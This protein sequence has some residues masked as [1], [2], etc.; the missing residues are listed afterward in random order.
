MSAATPTTRRSAAAA[1]AT[2]LAPAKPGASRDA[3]TGAAGRITPPRTG[4]W[5]WLRVALVVI[6]VDQL[7]KTLI[8]GQFALHDTYVVTPFFNIVRA[9]NPGAA[10]SFL[11]GAAGWQRWFFVGLGIA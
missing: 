7:T 5:G 6:V 10:F 9:H 1:A 4:L 3:L 11:A 2:S 8:V